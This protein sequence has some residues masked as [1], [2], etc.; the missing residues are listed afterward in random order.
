MSYRS[1]ELLLMMRQFNNN[2]YRVRSD[3]G[4]KDSIVISGDESGK[5]YIWDLLEGKFLRKLNHQNNV[6]RQKPTTTD[7]EGGY[8]SAANVISCVTFCRARKEWASAAGDGN[9]T[10]ATS[11]RSLANAISVQVL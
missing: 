10:I 9:L 5:I 4:L 11:L 3:F 6:E 7:L 8:R 1:V 2:Q